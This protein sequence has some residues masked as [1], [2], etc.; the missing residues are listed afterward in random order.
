M[1]SWPEHLMITASVYGEMPVNKT[2]RKR[3]LVR[4]KNSMIKLCTP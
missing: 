2:K 4:E 1:L 3:E